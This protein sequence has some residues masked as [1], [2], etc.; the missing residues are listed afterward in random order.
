VPRARPSIGRITIRIWNRNPYGARS[1]LAYKNIPVLVGSRGYGL[2]VDVPAAVTFHLGSPYPLLYQRECF[3][4]TQAARGSRAV[5]WSR[6]A[7]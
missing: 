3:E 5:A 7:A 2:F 6:S 1:E 4:A